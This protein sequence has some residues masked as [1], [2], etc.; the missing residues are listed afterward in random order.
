[1]KTTRRSFLGGVAVASLP[2]A[3]SASAIVA[4][5]EITPQQQL[6]SAVE[7]LEAAMVAVHGEGVQLIRNG[8][9]LITFLEP[10]KPRIVEWQGKGFYEVEFT[11]KIRPIFLVERRA[12]CDC[13]K[14]G[15][16]FK[17]TPRDAKH[18]GVRYMFEPD[19]RLALVR[20]IGG[21]V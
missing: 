20:K 8:N 10:F 18:L 7:V 5:P 6:D 4:V 16:C 3:A 1:M 2:V 17:L 11:A 19:L 12:D 15:R 21:A 9:A 13:I 14:L